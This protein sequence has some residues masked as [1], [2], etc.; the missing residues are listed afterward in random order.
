MGDFLKEQHLDIDQK[1]QIELINKLNDD[2]IVKDNYTERM[3]FNDNGMSKEKTIRKVAEIPSFLFYNEPLLKEYHNA[4]GQ[5]P[6][7]AKRCLRTWLTLHPEY[8]CNN[9]SI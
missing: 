6:E 3:D 7:Y 5:N 2:D 8:K 9:G 1:G 4:I